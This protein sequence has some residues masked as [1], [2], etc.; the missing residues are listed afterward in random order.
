MRRLML[1]TAVGT[2]MFGVAGCA[3]GPAPAER[4]GAASGNL[5]DMAPTPITAA[6]FTVTPVARFDSPWA[7]AFIPGTPFAIITERGGGMKLWQ[8]DGPVRAIANVPSVAAGGQGGQGDVI[9]IGPGD[10]AGGVLIAFSWVEAGPGGYGAVVATAR[11]DP[12]AANPAL[13]DIRRIWRQ[14]PFMSGRGHF[15]HRLALAPDGRHLFISSG[16]RQAFEPAQSLRSNLG[17]ILRIGIDGSIPADNP[18]AARAP[19]M[20]STSPAEERAMAEI[21]SLGHRN[22]L[23]IAFDADGRL[24][25]VEMGP[26]GGDELNRIERGGNYG[27]PRVSNGDH[28]DGRN[29]P[30]HAPGDGFIAPSLWWNPVISPAGL[31]IYSGTSFPQWRGDAFIPALSGE[32]LVR[33]DLDGDQARVGDRWAMGQRIRAVVEGPEGD[34][35]L[36]E[37]GEGEGAGRLLR[38]SPRR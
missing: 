30:D 3:P 24:W 14:I 29:I 11:L 36:L 1:L 22:P 16:E 28:Y 33:V 34:I 38:L 32:S 7:M 2:T 20:A 18:Y 12:S 9:V 21:W 19:Q 37:D 5:G 26:A 23:G 13:R 4:T 6:P 25:E 27:Y 8:P 10:A 31:M 15:G 35:W 17:K